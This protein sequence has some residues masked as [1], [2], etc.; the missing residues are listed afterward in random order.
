MSSINNPTSSNIL[1]ILNGDSIKKGRGAPPH[2]INKYYEKLEDK[3]YNC[4]CIFCSTIIRKRANEDMRTHLS[5][6][7]KLP[8]PH[9]TPADLAQFLKDVQLN[10]NALYS[11]LDHPIGDVRVHGNRFTKDSSTPISGIVRKTKKKPAK[12]VNSLTSTSANVS[13]QITENPKQVTEL[14]NVQIA[15][16]FASNGI[17]A[18]VVENNFFQ[19]LFKRIPGYHTLLGKDLAHQYV[20]QVSRLSKVN[21]IK[22]L[23]KAKSLTLTVYKRTFQNNISIYA[24]TFITDKFKEVYFDCV[25]K[26]THEKPEVEV[27]KSLL[28]SIDTLS[29]EVQK[30]ISAITGDSVIEHMKIYIQQKFRSTL[31]IN[32]FTHN[33]NSILLNLLR[34]PSFT[35]LLRWADDVIQLFTTSHKLSTF[36]TG[37]DIS[38]TPLLKPS[39]VKFTHAFAAYKRLLDN[40]NAITLTIRVP[41]VMP[42]LS[43]KDEENV[44][45]VYRWK[46]LKEF[47]SIFQPFAEFSNKAET[48]NF[49]V[50][51]SFV[52]CITLA[53]DFTEAINETNYKNNFTIFTSA[54]R[55]IFHK[56][57]FN[58]PGIFVLA[59]IF[60]LDYAFKPSST[61]ISM[62]EQSFTEICY[63]HGATVQGV[64]MLMQL[65]HHFL[66]NRE[67][68]QHKNTND[69][70]WDETRRK[71]GTLPV[72]LLHVVCNSPSTDHAFSRMG[73]FDS[74]KANSTE[75]SAVEIKPRLDIYLSHNIMKPQEKIK[76]SELD[77]LTVVST[78]EEA[79]QNIT[80]IEEQN[81]DTTDDY[82]QDAQPLDQQFSVLRNLF[83]DPNEFSQFNKRKDTPASSVSGDQDDEFAF[84]DHIFN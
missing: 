60:D 3:P 76:S 7:P 57:T 67:E 36:L 45:D 69:G 14:I 61:T 15:L 83:A 68:I 59:L 72:H 62:A 17:P 22:E 48:S 18:T 38:G 23:E 19:A 54:I 77:Q 28:D 39:E 66:N 43:S 53:R 16:A 37:K 40:S 42:F 41:G 30:K 8:P 79:S 82:L 58:N 52:E 50:S 81:R 35:E 64:Q 51:K 6:C 44:S 63:S 34:D 21:S 5:T 11:G 10:P 2:P 25:V 78:E 32:C 12:N 55:K 27:T 29:E 80:F 56:D 46:Q 9:E 71:F 33:L 73:W 13:R 20:P 70:Y 84:I 74:I 65:F 24:L 4:R 49:T 1:N 26:Q 31:F 47:V 75:L